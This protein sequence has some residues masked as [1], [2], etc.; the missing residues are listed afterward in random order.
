MHKCAYFHYRGAA[1]HLTASEAPPA[2]AVGD[3]VVDSS[4]EF[5]RGCIELVHSKTLESGF[6]HGKAGGGRKP[7]WKSKKKINNPSDGLA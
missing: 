6:W 7:N 1:T 4:F 5:V 3:S 2:M